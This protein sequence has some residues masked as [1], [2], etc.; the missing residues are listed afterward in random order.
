MFYCCH[1][2]QIVRKK[3]SWISVLDLDIVQGTTQDKLI[4]RFKTLVKVIMNLNV[5]AANSCDKALSH[6]K[7]LLDN[8]LKELRLDAIKV[9]QE[10]ERLGDFYFKK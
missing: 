4:T 6:F 1:G 8:D 2:I 9:V 7:C 5:L 3:P 10:D